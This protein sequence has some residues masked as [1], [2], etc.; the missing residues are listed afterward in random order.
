MSGR[1]FKFISVSSM[2]SSSSCFTSFAFPAAL[3]KHCFISPT[4]LSKC[5]LHHGTLLRLNFHFTFSVTKNS[6]ILLSLFLIH[7]EAF[8][9]IL[10]LCEYVTF[11]LPQYITISRFSACKTLALIDF[12]IFLDALIWLGYR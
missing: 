6:C 4:I 8:S 2:N 1:L 10:V 9:N 5:P 12:A 3:Y 7:F 11:G